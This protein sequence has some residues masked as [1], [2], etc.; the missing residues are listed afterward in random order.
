MKFRSYCDEFS[1]EV[2][3]VDVNEDYDEER[4]FPYRR[5]VFNGDHF[6]LW[7]Y[8]REARLKS[9]E[10]IAIHRRRPSLLAQKARKRT[11]LKWDLSIKRG[12]G[13]KF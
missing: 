13:G 6:L 3:E 2:D 7:G 11:L 8:I 9:V 1:D 4:C 10:S 12:M 5:P